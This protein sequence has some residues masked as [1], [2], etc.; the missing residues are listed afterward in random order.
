MERFA[1]LR[2]QAAE[3]ILGEA[4]LSKTRLMPGGYR[5]SPLVWDGNSSGGQRVA[6]GIYSYRVTV[7]TAEGETGVISGRMV[8][9]N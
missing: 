5:T 7:T 8:I 3:V 2:L 9:I 1:V 4:S 6:A